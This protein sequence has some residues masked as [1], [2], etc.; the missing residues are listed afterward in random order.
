MSSSTTKEEEDDNHY[1]ISI[2]ENAFIQGCTALTIN[3]L[4]QLIYTV[5]RFQRLI[6]QPMILQQTSLSKALFLLLTLST[7]NAMH[8]LTFYY[9]LKH[10]Q[11]GATTAAVMKGLQ[12]VMVFC[13]SWL[14]DLKTGANLF[15]WNKC[16]SLFLVVTG[17]VL[18]GSLSH[19]GVKSSTSLITAAER[20]DAHQ[21][22]HQQDPKEERENKDDVNL[23][24]EEKHLNGQNTGGVSHGYGAITSIQSISH[25]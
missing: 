7:L 3:G 12:A 10:V 22:F 15:S 16:C 19:S 11:G 8:S 23:N 6:Y 4:W 18:Y 1:N 13:F 20:E 2:V 17:V 21:C 5:P 25:V 9:T 14:L 24:I